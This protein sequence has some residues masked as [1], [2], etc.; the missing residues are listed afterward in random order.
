MSSQYTDDIASTAEAIADAGAQVTFTRKTSIV[1]EASGD[2]V[3]VTKTSV[4]SAIRVR[5]TF[6]ESAKIEA[7]GLVLAKS[8]VLAVA[9]QGMTFDPQESDQ[10]TFAGTTYTISFPVDAIAPDGTPILYRVI[11]AV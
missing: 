10:F 5:A 4:T 9:A 2:V 6:R 11:G 1:D 8:I 3:P 7:G